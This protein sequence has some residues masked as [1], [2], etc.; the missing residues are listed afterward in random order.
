MK[1]R[2]SKGGAKASARIRD[3]KASDHDACRGLWA[4][5]TLVPGEPPRLTVRPVAAGN[6]PAFQ[7]GIDSVTTMLH[8]TAIS[9]SL[10]ALPE[11]R[12]ARNVGS[13]RPRP[14]A[15]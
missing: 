2:T 13:S 6:A 7:T 12:P 11:A 1:R 14:R 4:E 3:F 8:V 5:L 9:E 10:R 15:P